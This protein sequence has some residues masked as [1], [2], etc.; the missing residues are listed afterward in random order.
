MWF[1][2]VSEIVFDVF[3]CNF[4]AGLEEEKAS[5]PTVSIKTDLSLPF[6]GFSPLNEGSEDLQDADEKKGFRQ[7]ISSMDKLSNVSSTSL[8]NEK[9]FSTLET[10]ATKSS[11]PP[12]KTDGPSSDTLASS[13]PGGS[14]LSSA[15]DQASTEEARA[16]EDLKSEDLEDTSRQGTPIPSHL[17][18]MSCQDEDS[19]LSF[20]QEGGSSEMTVFSVK[21]PKVSQAKLFT[22][23]LLLVSNLFFMTVHLY[24]FSKYFSCLHIVVLFF[25]PGQSCSAAF[26]TAL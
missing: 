3:K 19:H 10:E 17:N 21:W 8:P 2:Q 23:D 15:Q 20:T 9:N 12:A 7:E 24:I 13:S 4:L 22:L 25:F 1:F 14:L 5:S 6:D 18:P 11:V 26:G 16:A